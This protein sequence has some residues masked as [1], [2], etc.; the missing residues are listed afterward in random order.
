[1]PTH[2]MEVEV[3]VAESKNRLVCLQG[4]RSDSELHLDGDSKK[5]KKK[6]KENVESSGEGRGRDD[7]VRQLDVFRVILSILRRAS[8]RHRPAHA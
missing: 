2:H 6:A 5:A 8:F 4:H 3:S 1:M 7:A